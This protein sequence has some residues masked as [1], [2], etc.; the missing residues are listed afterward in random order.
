MSIV[1]NMFRVV[2]LMVIMALLLGAAS[3]CAY[4]MFIADDVPYHM[5][6]DEDAKH[7]ILSGPLAIPP[8]QIHSANWV[9]DAQHSWRRRHR[10]ASQQEAREREWSHQIRRLAQRTTDARDPLVAVWN[11]QTLPQLGAD[12]S[13]PGQISV[14]LR[15]V[16]A[17][18]ADDDRVH[19]Q[20]S[21]LL[22]E[23]KPEDY[24]PPDDRWYV[25]LVEAFQNFGKPTVYQASD[26]KWWRQYDGL[27]LACTDGVVRE[28]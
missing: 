7:L 2:W 9:Y 14:P 11:A 17:T 15:N 6:L 4:R 23:G 1:G 25:A 13:V 22:E 20:V 24:Q 16:C 19:L 5:H 10:Y 27:S 3:L 8:A 12:Y 26:G 28:P 18:V 21:I